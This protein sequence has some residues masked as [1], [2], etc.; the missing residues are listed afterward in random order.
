MESRITHNEKELV[1]GELKLGDSQFFGR[2]E[3]RIWMHQAR[4]PIMEKPEHTPARCSHCAGPLS[5]DLIGT[6]V[7]GTASAFY[8]FN[9]AELR[10]AGARSTATTVRSGKGEARL[11]GFYMAKEVADVSG[12]DVVKG[13]EAMDLDTSWKS[14]KLLD[15]LR[16]FLAVQQ[17]RAEAYTRWQRAKFS[18]LQVLE[19]ESLFLMP[20]ISRGDLSGLL[21]AVQEQEKKKLHLTCMNKS[22]KVSITFE[23][24]RPSERLVSHEHCKFG[25]AAEHECQHVREIT[26]AD[27]TEDAEADAEYESSLKEAIRGVQVAVT[28]INDHLEEVRYEIDALQSE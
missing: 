22:K 14:A 8:G 24:S 27:G 21:K 26:E 23:P 4:Y 18:S 12:G 19:M 1:L 7:G 10:E 11:S 25:E 16:R 9:H 2:E 13:I 5:K 15:L 28:N 17:R 3:R 20:D 6:G